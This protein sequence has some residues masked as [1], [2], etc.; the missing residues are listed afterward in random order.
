MLPVTAARQSAK[1]R[2]ACVLP[3]VADLAGGQDDDIGETPLA[4]SGGQLRKAP[5]QELFVSGERPHSI[6]AAVAANALVEFVFWQFAHQ[7]G[8]HDSA[9]VHMES[10]PPESGKTPWKGVV[11]KPNRKTSCQVS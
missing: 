6:I 5:D 7:L 10:V 4:R 8:K 1:M 11:G 2:A 3:G 9:F